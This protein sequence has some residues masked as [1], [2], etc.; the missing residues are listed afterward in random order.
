MRFFRPTPAQLKA[1]ISVII[2]EQVSQDYAQQLQNQLIS[3]IAGIKF[4][5]DIIHFS[6]GS[7]LAL[8]N[9]QVA[10]FKLGLIDGTAGYAPIS[11]NFTGEAIIA[12]EN[13]T[14]GIYEP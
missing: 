12:A 5:V 13:I 2:N 6:I 8:N 9:L 7:Q 4:G 3:A 1:V 10:D 14:V 11:L